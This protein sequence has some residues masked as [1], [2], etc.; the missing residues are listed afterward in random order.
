M[1]ISEAREKLK[2]IESGQEERKDVF[3]V[4]FCGV[5]S[6]GKSSILNYLL[7]YNGFLLP[8]GIIPITKL[9]TRIRYGDTLN[10]W[11]TN[12]NGKRKAI[13]RKKFEEYVV[14]IRKLPKEF[15]E[16]EIHMPAKILKSGVEFLDTPGF[17]DTEGDE[18][19]MLTREAVLT[20]DFVVF[21]TSASQL[22]TQFEQ[23]YLE[24]LEENVG[25]YCMIV[26]RMD[27]C[28]TEKDRE[29]IVDK[30][31]ELMNGK[32]GRILNNLIG[33]SYFFTIAAGAEK[34]MNG[35]DSYI[36]YILGSDNLKR[37]LKDSTGKNIRRYRK[38]ELSYQILYEEEEMKKALQ[39]LETRH[40]ESLREQQFKWD[41]EQQAAE[42]RELRLIKLY[43]KKIEEETE[44]IVR[45]L[46][47]LKNQR[48]INEFAG[49]TKAYINERMLPVAQAIDTELQVVSQAD[50]VY[51]GF[52]SAIDSFSVPEP[53]KTFVKTRDGLERAIRTVHN[54]LNVGFIIDDGYS[55]EYREYHIP[56]VNAV[57]SGLKMKLNEI[58][59]RKISERCKLPCREAKSGL[60]QELAAKSKMLEEWHM[61]LENCRE[62]QEE[63]E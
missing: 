40:R 54:I 18:L 39:D 17:Q 12:R 56:A 19:E 38:S 36:A 46:E 7:E 4:A 60:E 48:I 45:K 14:G 26:N 21:C 25:N 10:F 44:Q 32:G 3:T 28:H 51:V 9:V 52:K 50:S 43:Q 63:G 27:A 49:E 41:K 34:T 35:F 59:E 23:G 31:G 8:V 42:Q 29:D 30:A 1:Q 57:K 37:N 5:F 53:E 6:S 24:E 33:R 16:V 55:Y 13:S 47:E 22:G 61:L 20:S 62:R 11:F 15:R 2:K 58:V